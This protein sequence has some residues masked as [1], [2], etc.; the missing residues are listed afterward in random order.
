MRAL[1]TVSTA[2]SAVNQTNTGKRVV[3]QRTD[4]FTGL[5]RYYFRA[6]LIDAP[7]RFKTWSPK[8]EGR[9]ASRHYSVMTFE[10][11]LLLPVGEL[12][13]DDAWLFSWIPGPF[14]PRIG[15]QMEARRPSWDRGTPHARAA[16]IAFWADMVRPDAIPRAYTS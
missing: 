13:A 4:F 6:I 5:P 1:P 11:S 10:E 9:S 2:G 12:A 3:L 15:E 16:K 8:G 7:L 14:I